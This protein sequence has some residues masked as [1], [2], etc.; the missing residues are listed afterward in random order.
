MQPDAVREGEEFTGRFIRDIDAKPDD[1]IVLFED[2]M[3]IDR[4]HNGGY[5]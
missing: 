2:E 1:L 4:L 3:P 5:S